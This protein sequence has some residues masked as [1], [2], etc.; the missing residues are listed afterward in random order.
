[1][2]KVER[3]VQQILAAAD[4]EIGGTRPQDII[5]HDTRLYARVIREGDLG[6]GEAYMDGWW[7]A[8]QLD[9]FF[10]HLLSIDPMRAIK[11]SPGLALEL[12]KVKLVNQQTTKKAKKD[13]S[14]H[15]NIGNDL[16]KSMLDK[17]MIYTCAYWKNAKNLD[18]AQEAKL[19]LVCKK[20]ELKPGMKVLDIGCG[21]GGFAK[22]AAERYGVHVTGVTPAKEQV[23]LARKNTK[24]LDVDILQLDYRDVTGSFDRIVSIGMLEHVGG[25]NYR[26]FFNKCNELLAPNGIMMHHTIGGSV[27]YRADMARWMRKYIFPG[28][29]LPTLGDISR[30]VEHTFAIEDVQNLGED[31]HRTLLEWDANFKKHYP[32]LDHEVYDER[33]YRMWEYYLLLCGGLFHSHGL[34]LWQIVF[35]RQEPAP[36]YRSPR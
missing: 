1:M 12:V 23:E 24:G 20:L 3:A 16:Y 29:Y 15:Y 13:V 35:R 26:T 19:D 25:K 10:A 33:F 34:Y 11:M 30:A 7:D 27:P 14:H 28:T 17:R 4:I 36:T 9:M 21:W 32:T 2:K 22:F 18:Q 8:N 5:I 31:Y 6:L